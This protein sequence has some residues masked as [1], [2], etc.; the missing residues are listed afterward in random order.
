MEGWEQSAIVNRLRRASTDQD[1]Q[2]QISD[3]RASSAAARYVITA[4]ILAWGGFLTYKYLKATQK[5]E[6]DDWTYVNTL[7]L[8]ENP[9]GLLMMILK[10]WLY[11]LLFGTATAVLARFFKV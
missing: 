6:I 3:H 8:G 5:A 7:W 1:I 11:T 2:L 10:I 9:S 4:A